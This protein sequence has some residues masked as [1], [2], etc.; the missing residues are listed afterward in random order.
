MFRYHCRTPPDARFVLTVDCVTATLHK[1]TAGDGYLYY[2]RQ[3]AAHDSTEKGRQTLGDYYSARGESPGRW[4]GSGL[5][6]LGIEPGTAVSEEQMKALFGEGRHPDADRLEQSA[7]ADARAAGATPE[8]AHAHALAATRLGNPFKIYDGGTEF[9]QQCAHAY[10]DY[11]AGLGNDRRDAL[12]DDVRARIRTDVATTMFTQQY[13]RAPL[14]TRE[15]S[16]WAATNSRQLT[17]AVAGWDFT[18]SPVKSVSALW[19][20]APAPVADAILDAHRAA[21]HDAI[22]YLESHATFTRLG[23]NGIRQVDVDGMIIALF[24][25]RESRSGDPDLHTHAVTSAKVRTPD[26]RWRAIDGRMFY[27]HLVTASEIY[28]TRL[29]QHLERMLGLVFGER[30]GTDPSKRPIREI[31]GVALELIEYWSKRDAAI[32]AHQGDLE[33][34]FRQRHGRDPLPGEVY[35]LAEQATLDTRPRK[36]DTRPEAAQRADWHTDA[37]ALLGDPSNLAAMIATALNQALPARAVIDADWIAR[38]ATE[39][40]D[41]ISNERATWRITHVRSETQ[42]RIRGAVPPEQWAHVSDAVVAAALSPARS[43]PRTDPDLRA[44]P[45]LAP[46]PVWLQ[47]A[48]TSNVHTVSE[49]GEYTSSAI[50]SAE[51]RLIAAAQLG[52]A[53]V[54]DDTT[55]DAAIDAYHQRNPDLTLNAGQLG[56]IGEFATSARRLQLCTAPAGTGKTT[57]MRVLADAWTAAGGKVVGFAPTAS[58]AAVLQ[59]DLGTHVPVATFDTLTHTLKTHT[60]NLDELIYGDDRPPAEIADWIATIGP[61]TLVIVDEFAKMDTRK[62]DLGFTRFLLPRGATIRG[63]GDPAQLAA[64]GPGGIATDINELTPTPTLSHVVRFADPAER[65]ASLAIRAGDPTGLG[66]Y[67]DHQRIHSGTPATVATDTYT[68]WTT[69]HNNGLDTIMLAPTRA[70]V[71]ELNARARADR[72][73]RIPTPPGATVTL[74]DRLDASV[75]DT[76]CTRRNRKRIRFGDNDFVRNGYR[77]IVTAVHPDGRITARHL[78]PGREHGHTVT[79]PAGYV[80]RH[81]TLGY[82]STIDAAQGITVDTC[83]GILSG[84]ES[85]NQLYVMLTRGRR[86][87]QVYA[88][89]TIDGTEQSAFT[90]AAAHPPTVVDRLTTVLGRDGAQTSATTALRD[91]LN[92]HRRLG[93]AV[94]AYLDTLGHTLEHAAGDTVL[95]RIDTAADQVVPHLTD[96]AAY[97]V[98]RQQLAWLA[99]TGTDPTRALAQAVRVRELGSAADP[100]AVLHWRL[101]K[102]YPEL[103]AA[104]G[105]LPWLPSIPT[106]VHQH[107]PSAGRYLRARHRIIGTLADQIRTETRFTTTTSMPAWTRPLTGIDPDLL[108]DLA[109]WRAA[110]HVQDADRQPTGPTRYPALEREYQQLLD[111]RVTE[112]V[113]D[114]NL[115]V[116]A[117]AHVVK[118]LDDRI[119]TDPAWPILAAQIDT[120]HRAGLD[121]TA[122]LATAIDTRPLPAEM[123]AAALLYRLELDPGAL[124]SDRPDAHLRPDWLP[125]LHAVVGGPLAEQITGSSTW[126]TLVAAVDNIEPSS[127]WTPAEL[128]STAYELLTAH[129]D[130]GP[131]L[132]P[133]QLATALAWR[134]EMLRST[135]IDADLPEPHLRDADAHAEPDHEPDPPVPATA[136]TEPST[137]GSVAHPSPLPEPSDRATESLPITSQPA[138]PDSRFGRIGGLVASGELG[139]A[140]RDTRN[141]LDQLADDERDILAT[142]LDTLENYPYP[143]ALQRLRALWRAQ[144]QHRALITTVVPADDPG[145]YHPH[146]PSSD[147]VERGLRVPR[148]HRRDTAPRDDRRWTDHARRRTDSTAPEPESGAVTEYFADRLGIDDQPEHAS[149]SAGYALDYDR[150]AIPGLRGTPC[151]SCWIERPTADQHQPGRHSDDGLC[152]DCRDADAPA[153]A[154]LPEAH[155]RGDWI[156]ARATYIRLHHARAATKLLRDWWRNADP[157]TRTVLADWVRDHPEPAELPAVPTLAPTIT[158]PPAAPIPAPAPPAQEPV[159]VTLAGPLQ[160]LDDHE[161]GKAITGLRRR[162]AVARGNRSIVTALHTEPVETSNRPRRSAAARTAIIAAITTARA[163]RT[164]ADKLAQSI[165][166]IDAELH[167]LHSELA[168]TP[169]LK[170]A[171]RTQLRASI[172]TSTNQRNAMNTDHRRAHHAALRAEQDAT[173]LAGP[174]ENWADHLTTAA[175]SDHTESRRTGEPPATFTVRGEAADRDLTRLEHK[176][177]E[178]KAE[179]HRRST[180]TVEQR[181]AEQRARRHPA[182]PVQSQVASDHPVEANRDRGD[183]IDI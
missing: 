139:A 14:D 177:H 68:G 105:P 92:P 48:D 19:A 144:P 168:A 66:Y 85:R 142:V 70:L 38:T 61:D 95:A 40:T 178:H 107:D 45:D 96:A 53:R 180:L 50:L 11:N 26:G 115:A 71:T 87:N 116:H 88:T 9:Q 64:I 131:P 5:Q 102:L 183:G 35:E 98:M 63:I 1:L 160:L 33:S 57:A 118:Q 49:T 76:I 12:P 28:N 52:G 120:A 16:G 172:E 140:R 31:V 21:V 150:A 65:A 24:E 119:T 133:D 23:R 72:L 117:W 32:T 27:Q 77:W 111:A 100:A 62:L 137:A 4:H 112:A 124:H 80:A 114:T 17:T 41:T 126:P 162:I 43:V 83:H 36:H 136:T 69:D 159:P 123:P 163:A 51:A 155:T 153:I 166:D 175:D 182:P 130:D 37:A 67:L 93:A 128:L 79:L 97:P 171:A 42:R 39:V 75:G 46:A 141:L 129:L 90:D 174:P 74:A 154:E 58:A 148:R 25:H 173:R 10:G 56:V 81:V 54:L 176:L 146:T 94:D 86:N 18:F 109:V 3:V 149:P 78:L 7:Y 134:V 44:E 103:A 121:I 156:A 165:A 84:S 152:T 106:A 82:A 30:P 15:L 179:L 122:R 13:E 151:V 132:R 8:Q 135:T 29:E 158:Q 125:D 181:R 164:T 55:I 143:I 73:A 104:D 161:L 47:R 167:T 60:P 99:L 157:E 145:I 2:V 169:R 91:A 108:A 22:A 89:T 59:N 20:L 138:P 101:T 170:R 34:Q 6:A 110:N 127:T 147:R 113:G